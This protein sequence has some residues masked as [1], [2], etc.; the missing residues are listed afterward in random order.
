[1]QQIFGN[2]W[3]TMVV[4]ISQVA[5]NQARAHTRESGKARE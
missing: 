2:I 1:V 5:L 4:A 3:G